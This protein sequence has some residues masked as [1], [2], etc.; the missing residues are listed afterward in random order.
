MLLLFLSGVSQVFG[1]DQNWPQWRG[2]AGS[3]LTSTV[4]D[5]VLIRTDQVLWCFAEQTAEM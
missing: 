3:G 2:P 5:D 1:D 4:G